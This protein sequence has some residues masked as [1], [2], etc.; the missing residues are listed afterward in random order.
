MVRLPQKDRH[1]LTGT[2]LVTGSIQIWKVRKARSRDKVGIMAGW[3]ETGLEQEESYGG[4]FFFFFKCGGN[5]CF[6]WAGFMNYGFLFLFLL[7]CERMSALVSS[8]LALC[9]ECVLTSWWALCRIVNSIPC[10][11]VKKGSILHC[12]RSCEALGNCSKR[13]SQLI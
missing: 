8:L 4:W 7:A 12:G 6:P 11:Q 9:A 3:E 2:S 13:G 10:Q 5:M 1:K